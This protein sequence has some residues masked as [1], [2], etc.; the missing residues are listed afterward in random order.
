MGLGFSF[1]ARPV[2]ATQPTPLEASQAM[3]AR[4]Q[5][6]PS[7]AKGVEV[8]ARTAASI[9]GGNSTFIQNVSRVVI[10]PYLENRKRVGFDEKRKKKM[11]SDLKVEKIEGITPEKPRDQQ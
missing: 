1:G 7:L 9:G 8:I 5:Q 11:V 3:H 6:H 4:V 10:L 2:Q